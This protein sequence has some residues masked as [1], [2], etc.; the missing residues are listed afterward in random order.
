MKK[1]YLIAILLLSHMLN[2]YSGNYTTISSDINNSDIWSG[3][4]YVSKSI[5]FDSPAEIT[6]MPGTVIKLAHGVSISTGYNTVGFPQK[7][8]I[9]H[10]TEINPI[11][12][13]SMDDNSV[14]ETI[15]ESDGEPNPGDW[16][17][18]YLTAIETDISYVNVRYGATASSSS[19]YAAL[20]VA[21]KNSQVS[22]V[23]IAHCAQFGIIFHYNA[24][25]ISSNFHDCTYSGV[26][27]GST[28]NMIDSISFDNCTFINNG[29]SGIGINV[30]SGNVKVEDCSFENNE[31]NGLSVN[32]SNSSIGSELSSTCF[33]NNCLFKNNGKEA[34]S[35]HNVTVNSPYTGNTVEGNGINAFYITKF[36]I[37]DP[38][39][40]YYNNGIPYAIDDITPVALT[41]HEGTIIK[42]KGTITVPKTGEL[43]V[44]GT[45]TNPVIFTSI[46]DDAIAGDTNNDGEATSPAEETVI[47]N[48]GTSEI[49]YAKFYYSKLQFDT[50]A[51]VSH[52]T[53]E[54]V[55]SNN[56]A[57]ILGVANID[58][59]TF[60]NN[61]YGFYASRDTS[62]VNNCVFMNND[63]GVLNRENVE[64]KNSRFESNRLGVYNEYG[65][66]TNLGK[67][68]T[69]S[70][71]NNIFTNNTEY[72]IY[73]KSEEKVFAI[74]NTFDGTSSAEIDAKIYDDNEDASLGEVIFTPWQNECSLDKLAKPTGIT[75]VCENINVNIYSTINSDPQ[76]SIN[77]V[78]EPDTAGA[79]SATGNDVRVTW[80]LAHIG[81]VKLW[82]YL[83]EA[84]CTGENSDTLTIERIALPEK[85]EITLENQALIATPSTDYQ[86]YIRVGDA[87]S[88]YLDPISGAVEQSYSPTEDGAYVVEVANKNGCTSLSDPYEY[89][90]SGLNDNQLSGFNIYPNPNNGHFSIQLNDEVS[91]GKIIIT[92]VLGKTVTVQQVVTGQ[93]TV[94]V[95]V[96]PG[97]YFV[98]YS[99]DNLHNGVLKMIVK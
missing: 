95:D 87:I 36:R 22:N 66:Y 42:S 44:Y 41:I 15:D 51:Q 80:N 9:L 31:Y 61:F 84:E 29:R 93:N 12:I 82:A 26:G 43:H 65:D 83:S 94:I 32:G 58:S 75:E 33:I 11:I 20:R 34:V 50:K 73:N 72:D 55:S 60:N 23:D 14:G 91:D 5:M 40:L 56:A 28:I 70:I 27:S 19:F 4:V 88:G 90:N 76:A 30:Y 77:W 49:T 98:N 63:A 67:N 35:L 92:D 16:N 45:K 71:G 79:L 8:L 85:P 1:I 53:F 62:Q 7:E 47:L 81:E 74:K 38:S 24:N 46:S 13:T 2:M 52:S 86:W 3:T 59:C 69:D 99:H 97:I 37:N 25:I 54:N 78:I 18:I 6:V 57:A 48:K 17:Q 39:S 64:V 68:S 10:G 96:A 21:S 89:V